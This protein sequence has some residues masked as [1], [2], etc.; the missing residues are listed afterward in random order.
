VSYRVEFALGAAVTFHTLPPDGQDALIARAVGLAEQPWAD[1][2]VRRPGGDPAFREATFGD[3]RGL[4]AFQDDE[5]TEVVRIF[6][7][8]W[9]G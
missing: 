8:I 1:A 6:E 7:I 3:G 5:N 2:V 9:I 4:C